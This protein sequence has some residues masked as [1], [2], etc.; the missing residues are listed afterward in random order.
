MVERPE[1][2]FNSISITA[3]SVSRLQWQQY[4]KYYNCIELFSGFIATDIFREQPCGKSDRGTSL[5]VR[6]PAQ[7]EHQMTSHPK[8]NSTL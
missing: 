8:K 7:I 6:Q 2:T 4:V 1:Q 3:Q 5:A